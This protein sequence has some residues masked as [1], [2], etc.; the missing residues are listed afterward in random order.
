[1]VAISFKDSC[2]RQISSLEAKESCDS[3]LWTSKARTSSQ[4]EAADVAR[5]QNHES[6]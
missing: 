6:G 4:Y 5:T 2:K 1:M 3:I